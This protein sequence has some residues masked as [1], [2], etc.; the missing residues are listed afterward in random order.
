MANPVF[1]EH[2]KHIEI[3]CHV[4]QDAY[5]DGFIAPLH[6]RSKL[7]VADLFTKALSLKQFSDLLSKL[8]LVAL[9]P[10]PTCGGLLRME[11]L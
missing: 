3:D 6:V 4:V 7:Q 2:T 9:L 1:H 11:M 5:K 8:G 10:S